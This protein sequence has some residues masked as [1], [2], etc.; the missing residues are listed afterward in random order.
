MVAFLVPKQIKVKSHKGIYTVDF[1]NKI[2][3]ISK[4]IKNKK[5][6][7][8]VDANVYR[9]YKLLFNDIFNKSFI[10]KIEAYEKNKSINQILPIYKKLI[11]NRI[12][13]N[14]LM[15]V[16]GGGIIQDIGC[17]ISST[18]IRGLEWYFFPTTLLAQA[19]SCIGSKSSI[20]FYDSK[21][22]IGT[23]N[24]PNKVFIISDFLKSLSKV[25]IRS[26]IGEIFKVHMIKSKR[27]YLE[28]RKDYIND[29]F[30]ESN[31]LKYIYSSLQIKKK[32]IEVDEFDE[33]IRN[34]FNYG[35]SFGHALESATNYQIPHGIAVTMGIF[36]AN[37][38][39]LNKKFISNYNFNITSD[40]LIDNFQSFKKVNINYSKFKSALKKD[41]KN[42]ITKMALILPI[43]D[44]M[45]V[46]KKLFTNNTQFWLLI[47]KSL[48][49]LKKSIRDK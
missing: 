18:Y 14:H 15:I 35:H 17:F 43:G 2:S 41:K 3:K 6:F 10:I 40:I 13:K 46:E 23:F 20:N 42:T 34:I 5:I 24:P 30:T 49:T 7:L 8:I 29:F 25:D 37:V 36:V 4:I 26:G 21:N 27:S 48:D 31:L 28:L 9:I 19:D 32:Y 12:R 1:H 22:I 11:K 38:F 44:N 47:K 39:A 16:I 33:N 45:F